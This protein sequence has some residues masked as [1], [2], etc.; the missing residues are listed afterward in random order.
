MLFRNNADNIATIKCKMFHIRNIFNWVTHSHSVWVGYGGISR[1]LVVHITISHFCFSYFMN[2]ND[3][4]VP[5]HTYTYA[6]MHEY[7]TCVTTTKEK[8]CWAILCLLSVNCCKF[9]QS[10]HEFCIWFDVQGLYLSQ[11]F[12][13]NPK[14]TNK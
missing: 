7:L 8:K 14:T 1:A 3:K 9:Y 10:N 4:M 2:A 11:R 6:H 12:H 13:F 5:Q